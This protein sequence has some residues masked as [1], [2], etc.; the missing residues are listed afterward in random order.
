MWH[1][2][3]KPIFAN[4]FSNNTE[5]DKKNKLIGHL[6]VILKDHFD[7][8]PIGSVIDIVDELIKRGWKFNID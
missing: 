4:C 2:Q 1:G 3:G 6:N 7:Y 8:V 5:E